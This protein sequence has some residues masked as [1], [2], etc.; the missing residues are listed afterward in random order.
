MQPWICDIQD[1]QELIR[2]VLVE[3]IITEFSAVHFPQMFCQTIDCGGIEI[4]LVFPKIA[5]VD[6][7]IFLHLKIIRHRGK[8]SGIA[9]R[10]AVNNVE[11]AKIIAC[12]SCEIDRK[13]Q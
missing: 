5:A 1:G 7:A 13:I 11:K 8:I 6:V 2:A 9:A 4:E 12:R 3:E 10:K